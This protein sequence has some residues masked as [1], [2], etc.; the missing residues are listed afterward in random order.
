MENEITKVLEH[1]GERIL[2]TQQLAESY[3][4]IPKIITHNHTR[5]KDR[6]KNGVHYF[7]LT[8]KELKEFK[9][10]SKTSF[11]HLAQIEGIKEN[12]YRLSSAMLMKT[13]IYFLR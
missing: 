11:R 8:G 5:N 1:K 4:T 2:T 10:N 12:I 9:E 3:E 6:F 7:K 13:L